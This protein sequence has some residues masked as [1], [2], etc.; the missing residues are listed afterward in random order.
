MKNYKIIKKSLL[1]KFNNY[2]K[3]KNFKNKIVYLNFLKFNNNKF[4]NIK[5]FFRIF[6]IKNYKIFYI[7]ISN[8]RFIIN[9]K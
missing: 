2:K 4:L 8:I 1:L 9:N 6:I 7:Y 3:N 5:I